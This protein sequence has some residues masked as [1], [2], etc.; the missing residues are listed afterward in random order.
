MAQKFTV[1]HDSPLLAYLLE[2]FQG[3]SRTGVKAY[4]KDDR[5]VV[6]G[7]NHT[8]FD[9][10]LKKG[11]TIEIVSKG[12]SIGR[13][14]KIGAKEMLQKEGVAIVYEDDHLIVV[15][16][17]AGVPTIS[18]K[19]GTKD[20]KRIKSVQSLLTDYMHTEKRADIKAGTGTYSASSRVFVI[21]RLDR[22]TSGVLVFAKDQYTKE[23]MQSKW[24]EMVLERKYVAIV[25][26]HPD[27]EQGRIESW[28]TENEK[29]LKVSSSPIDNGGQRAVSHFKKLAQNKK[30]SVLEFELETGRKN[31]IRVHASDVMGLPIV[32]DKKYGSQCSF[33]GRIALHARSLV[34][35]NPFGGKVL[36]FDSPVPDSF[37]RLVPSINNR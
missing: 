22:D 34:F 20:G 33:G 36:R 6:N 11:D 15:E 35:R 8:A 31:Q 27:Q 24:N 16:K 2:V 37:G 9:W 7:Q 5:V 17:N 1:T 21:H 26:G 12:A 23:L 19:T 29:S 14:M 13:D 30:F 32:G 4:L 3:Q 18:Q 28:L 25:E 10:P